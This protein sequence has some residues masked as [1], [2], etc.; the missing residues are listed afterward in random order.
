V[1]YLLVLV[2]LVA[3]AIPGLSVVALVIYLVGVTFP[4]I[5]KQHTKELEDQRTNYR[6]VIEQDLKNVSQMISWLEVRNDKQETKMIEMLKAV[7][8]GLE[9]CES[10]MRQVQSAIE[11]CEGVQR[12]RQQA[13]GRDS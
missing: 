2:I 5:Q 6:V 12:F 10:V 8:S 13:E 1:D 7:Q 11:R 9:R 3:G 4:S